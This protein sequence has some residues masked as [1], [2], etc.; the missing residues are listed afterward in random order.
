MKAPLSW[1]LDHVDVPAA[2]RAA[3]VRGL[4]GMWAAKFGP[5]APVAVEVTGL[6]AS[7]AI[8]TP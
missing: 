3:E 5:A 1:I 4:G 6:S 7:T 2:L 8:G